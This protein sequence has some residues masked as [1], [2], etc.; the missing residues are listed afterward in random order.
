MDFEN[1][2]NH[3]TG[4][5]MVVLQYADLFSTQDLVNIALA[6]CTLWLALRVISISNLRGIK[7]LLNEKKAL[8]IQKK[9]K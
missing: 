2:L 4:I 3:L 6:L 9:K 7:D 1:L 8:K 5:L